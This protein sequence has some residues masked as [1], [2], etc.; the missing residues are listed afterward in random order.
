[1]GDALFQ[2]PY[3]QNHPCRLPERRLLPTLH[4]YFLFFKFTV[5]ARG[6]CLQ[7]TC[8]AWK[9]ASAD[10]DFA[11]ARLELAFFVGLLEA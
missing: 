3:A 10:A 7:I 2:T 5:F 6:S 8:G 1:M 9:S 4:K 11:A